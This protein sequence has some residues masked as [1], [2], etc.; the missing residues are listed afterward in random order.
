MQKTKGDK[1][2]NFN[3]ICYTNIIFN[4]QSHFE[5]NP[6]DLALLRHD[7][8]LHTVRLQEHLKDVPDYIIPPTLKRLANARTHQQRRTAGDGEGSSGARSSSKKEKTFLKRKDNPL[9][10][11]EFQG[12]GSKKAKKK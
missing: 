10:S 12:F 2:T 8:A 4:L 9:L 5:N 7:K 1:F 6:S 3:E 11:F